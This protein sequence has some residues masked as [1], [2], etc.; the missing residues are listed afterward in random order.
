MAKATTRDIGIFRAKTPGRN[1][2]FVPDELVQARRTGSYQFAAEMRGW[3]VQQLNDDFNGAR[4][5]RFINDKQGRRTIARNLGRL[6]EDQLA[7]AANEGKLDLIAAAGGTQVKHW[8]S[9][10]RTGYRSGPGWK[11]RPGADRDRRTRPN[12]QTVPRESIG[13]QA[14]LQRVCWNTSDWRLPT[15][16]AGDGGYPSEMGFGHEEWNFQM[17]DALD[18]YVFGY[19]YFQPSNQVIARSGGFFDIGFWAI[20]HESKDK[21]LV[22]YYHKATLATKEDLLRLDRHFQRSGIY[23]RRVTELL[24]VAPKLGEQSARKVLNVLGEFDLRFKCP[25]DQV[26]VLA[27]S[28]RVLLD[29]AVDG[30]SIGLYFAR[31]TYITRLPT[32]AVPRSRQRASRVTTGRSTPLAE[33]GY[34]REIGARS[35]RILRRHNALSNRFADWLRNRGYTEVLQEA[36]GVDVEFRSDSALWRAELKIC[37]PVGT[38]KSIREALGQLFEYNYFGMRQPADRWL[39][40]IDEEPLDADLEYIERIRREFSLPLSLAWQT[41]DDFRAEDLQ[42]TK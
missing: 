1:N 21:F 3:T 35:R 14:M 26:E 32:A 10:A 37:H 18:R 25:V 15:G 17:E 16:N 5:R 42:A 28:R 22:G 39:I 27:E 13:R 41:G 20:H 19:V 36:W 23:D 24:A 2:A 6:T 30:K 12:V 7:K 40:V 38:T 8:T 29:D 11:R 34:F 9:V 31:P 4:F 33:D